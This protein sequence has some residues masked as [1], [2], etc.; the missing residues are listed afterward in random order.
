MVTWFEM[1]KQE[2]RMAAQVVKPFC[3][4]LHLVDKIIDEI[5]ISTDELALKRQRSKEIGE[6]F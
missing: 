6:S 1:G 5:F 2:F 3:Y 4:Q